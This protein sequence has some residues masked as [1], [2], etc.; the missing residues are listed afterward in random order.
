MKGSARGGT[1]ANVVDVFLSV[2]ENGRTKS[3]ELVLSWEEGEQ[4]RG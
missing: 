1:R 2:Y 3:V 4:W